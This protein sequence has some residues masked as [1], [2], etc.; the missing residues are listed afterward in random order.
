[1]PVYVIGREAFFGT[2]YG[3]EEYF[4]ED[5]RMMMVGYTNR[6]PETAQPES[7]YF[8]NWWGNIASGF[9][10]YALSRLAVY[11]GG[12]YYLLSAKVVDIRRKGKSAT[13]TPSPE[14]ATAPARTPEAAATPVA[15]PAAASAPKPGPSPTAGPQRFDYTKGYDP[16]VLQYYRPDL[17]SK[18]AYLSNLKN[19]EAWQRLQKI[20]DRWRTNQHPI[21]GYFERFQIDDM[22]RRYD[23]LGDLAEE[24]LQEFAKGT[25][26]AK[27]LQQMTDR[28]WVGHYDLARLG[29]YWASWSYYETRLRL[30][31]AKRERHP[32]R[33]WQFSGPAIP[34]FS[35]A[36]EKQLRQRVVD[37]CQFVMERHAGTPWGYAAQYF[38]DTIAGR[39]HTSSIVEYVHPT[40]PRY[41]GP[42]PSAVPGPK[43][44]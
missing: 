23:D 6:G 3:H 29:L 32:Y 16:A 33:Y 42:K 30:L 13:A 20:I 17:A 25:V 21:P 24:M 2:D 7:A 18:A 39:F 15:R 19:S 40:D 38:Y 12:S 14:A 44:I 28:R 4:D 41:K 43:P 8:S 26:P 10:P 22:I 5:T 34:A 31:A 37:C 11:S 35:D 27:E 1:V 36:R 9:G